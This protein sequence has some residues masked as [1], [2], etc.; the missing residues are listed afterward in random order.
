MATKERL[1]VTVDPDLVAAGNQAVAA[2]LATSLSAWVNE[3][4]TA[5]A[6]QDRRLAALAE[7]VAGYEADHGEITEAEIA[8]QER[9]DRE[10]AT[11]VRGTGPRQHA[12]ARRRHAGAA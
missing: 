7:L 10:T 1:T 5:R 2:G 11:V 6:D 4:L 8:A 3:A 12:P 9:R